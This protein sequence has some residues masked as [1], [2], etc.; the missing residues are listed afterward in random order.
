LNAFIVIALSCTMKFLRV[1][2]CGK[3]N[4]KA[5]CKT[6]SKD[7]TKQTIQLGCNK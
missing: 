6:L 2:P 1:T 4:T 3:I 7:N 5:Q